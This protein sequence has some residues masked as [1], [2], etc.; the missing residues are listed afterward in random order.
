M[1]E[2]LRLLQGKKLTAEVVSVATVQ[3]EIGL[4]GA[5]TST[6]SVDPTVG[7]A[8]DVTHATDYPQL[9]N[10]KYGDTRLGGGPVILRGA[11]ANPIVV[12]RL[13]EAARAEDIPFQVLA[14]PR[15]TGT[16]ANAIQL[17]RGGVA[18]G[19]IGIPLRYMHTPSEVVSLADVENTARLLAAF[20]ERVEKDADFR[21]Q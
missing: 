21:P 14:F 12:Q 5:H 4:R 16:D 15:G 20:A 11:N 17:T 1:A 7:I 2:A 10:T 9:S 6:Y 8:V 19:L 3:E 13:M 18:T